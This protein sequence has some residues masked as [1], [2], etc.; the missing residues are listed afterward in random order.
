M[1][2]TPMTFV[3]SACISYVLVS[4]VASTLTRLAA[5]LT[6]S[7]KGNV[8]AKGLPSVE[9]PPRSATLQT[10]AFQVE[11]PC[12]D[13]DFVLNDSCQ[14]STTEQCDSNDLW[15]DEYKPFDDF[16]PTN[17][18]DDLLF[19]TG[20]FLGSPE[21]V[22]TADA[23]SVLET[24]LSSG[25]A[26]LA[27][28]ALGAGVRLCN[29]AWL[30]KACGEIQAAGIRLMPERAL[31]LVHVYGHARRAD[32]AVDLWEAQCDELGLD[33]EDGDAFKPP[34]A[35]E[36]YGAA[37]E[38]CAH[39][40][41][42][43]T[44]ARAAS[45]TGFQVPL[46]RQGQDAFLALA[47]WYAR[48]QDV[49]QAIVCYQA[50]RGVTGSAD[51]PTHRAILIACVRSADMAKADALF[52]DLI[53]A[54]ITPDGTSFSA[55]VCGHCTAGNI[56]QA[57]HYFHLLREMGI[58]PTALLFDAILDGC[59]WVN[60]PALVEQVLAEMEASDIR[61][62]T[63]TLSIL[64]RLHGRNRDIEQALT[65]FDELPKKHGLKLDGHAYGTLIS[66]CLKNDVY[67]M[68]WSTFDRMSAD[69]CMAHARTYESL[70]AASLRR[71]HLDNAVQVVYEAL[72][73]SPCDDPYESLAM[74]PRL[75]L[76]PKTIEDVLQLIGRRRQAARLGAPMIER[77]QTAGVV[78]SE[79][80]VE[81]VL[82]SA[83]TSSELSCSELHLRREQRDQWRNFQAMGA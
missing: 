52:Q 78:I 33:P 42:F 74:T 28:A 6:Q 59:A 75:R 30:V 32:L 55:M 21:A 77:L 26:K 2:M 20:N 10:P 41:D 69:G 23:N 13:D 12:K 46:S 71:G 53:S 5:W 34:P 76:Q 45:S 9:V 68:A 51:L 47:R 67:D 64:M 40:G 73:V 14:S 60:M 62:S 3:I 61:P 19:S 80:L 11:L 15:Q 8:T 22:V 31:E 29:P 43:E 79:S 27:D 58:V 49:G 57:M 66:V 48:R 17:G 4:I 36:L 81:S 16:E 83:D 35:A 37:L 1:T 63:T 82:R 72:G 39:S 18:M 24:A 56:D 38:A 25:D 7:R 50:V 54:G 44:A 65:L 70:I